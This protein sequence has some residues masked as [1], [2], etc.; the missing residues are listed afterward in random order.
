MTSCGYAGCDGA[1]A[2]TRGDHL[3]QHDSHSDLARLRLANQQIS[4]HPNRLPQ[5]VVRSFGAM[6]GQDY[7]NGLWAIGLRSPESSEAAVEEALAGAKIVRTWAMR[8]TLHFV[9]AEDVRWILALLAPRVIAGS[10][11]RRRQLEIDEPALIRSRAALGAALSGGRLL[12]RR[13]ALAVLE[14]GGIETAGQRGI[15][16]LRHLSLEGLLCQATAKAGQ[17]TFALLDEWVPSGRTMDRDAGL[18]ELAH[19]YFTSHG[20]ATFRDFVWWSGLTIAEA[21]VALGPIEDTLESETIGDVTHWMPPD[22]PVPRRAAPLVALLPAF[23]EYILGYTDRRL[24]MDSETFQ[25][26][27]PGGNGIFRPVVLVDG[28]VVGTWRLGNRA[29]PSAVVELFSP[30][31]PV[32]SRRVTAALRLCDE[33]VGAPGASG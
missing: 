1:R 14:A 28:R 33:F 6:Q 27:V 23:D 16:I 8:G 12:S 11:Y 13:Q 7:R 31:T 32:V 5:D 24:A 9:A 29:R 15:H 22:T 21:R 17:S 26:I 3:E 4:A 25:R 2:S 18:A 20:P 10:A 19:R 30:L